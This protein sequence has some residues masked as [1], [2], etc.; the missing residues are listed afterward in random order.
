MKMRYFD[1]YKKLVENGEIKANRYI[2][3][4]IKRV[5]RYKTQYK[6]YQRRANKRIKFIEKECC[7]TKGSTDLLKLALPQKVWLEVAWGFYEDVEVVKK[8][9]DTMKDYTV[10]EERRLI[11]QI[12]LVISRG[13]GKTTL[14]SAV[15]EAMQII[16]GENGADIQLLAY[17]NNQANILYNASRAMTD[18]RSSLLYLL[19]R[20]DLLTSTKQG[21]LFKPTNSLMRVK[22]SDYNSLDGT[23]AHCNIFDEVHTYDDDF[24]KVVNDGSSKKRKN[25]QTWYLTTNGTKRE[26]VF[27]KYF[28]FWVDILNGDSE[29]DHIMPWIYCLDEHEEI[30][31]PHLWQKAIPMLG[32]IDTLTVAGIQQEIEDAKNDPVAQAEIMAKTFNLPVNNYLAYFTN[33]ECAGNKE[34]FDK[35]LFKGTKANNALAVVGVDLSDVN[36]ICSITFM[37]VKGEE[38]Y[39]FSKKY[40]P[41]IRI[42]E[43]PKE[44]RDKYNEWEQKGY[45]HI[46][47]LDYND[48]HYVFED[49][50]QFMEENHILPVAVG[51]DKWGAVGGGVPEIIKLFSDF[52]GDIA[53]GISQTVKGLS[54]GLKIYKAKTKAGKIIFDDP[55]AT[56]CHMNVRVKTDA[57]GNVFPNKQ[58]AKDKIDVFAS[59]LDAFICYENEKE[60]LS[61]YFE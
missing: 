18:N 4:A 12:P 43:L 29:N 30:Y 61:V 24:I 10:I 49:I 40:M 46:H 45:L 25:W 8:D 48:Q 15:G 35:R 11:N 32:L 21:M 47:E 28:N 31:K 6:F 38:R 26:K 5:E 58:R 23:N 3:L 27:D 16:D 34:Q 20:Q 57:N 22:T 52:Y 17:D 1:R 50:Q 13:N 37:V 41:R 19:K 59:H 9:P 39:F 14:G 36:D 54:N 44:Q 55:I 51:Y 53:F 7:N 60:N 42:D 56:W 33:K 2:K